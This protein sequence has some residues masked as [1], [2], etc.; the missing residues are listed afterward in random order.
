MTEHAHIINCI[1]DLID[2][3]SGSVLDVPRAAAAIAAMHNK[4]YS[5][6]IVLVILKRVSGARMALKL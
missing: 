3:S 6:L 4:K 5:E 2:R 1:E